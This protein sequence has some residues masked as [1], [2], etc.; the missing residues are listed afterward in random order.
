VGQFSEF[1]KIKI[2]ECSGQKMAK[3]TPDGKTQL[4]K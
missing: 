4:E 1:I 3:K 2:L